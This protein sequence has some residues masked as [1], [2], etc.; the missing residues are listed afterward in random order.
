SWGGLNALTPRILTGAAAVPGTGNQSGTHNLALSGQ[1]PA[2]E[3]EFRNRVRE[4]RDL[5]KAGR[6]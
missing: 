4:I 5:L 6:P 2:F 1:R 3:L